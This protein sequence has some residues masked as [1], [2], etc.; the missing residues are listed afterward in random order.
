MRGAAR[1]QHLYSSVLQTRVRTAST[2]PFERRTDSSMVDATGSWKQ[3]QLRVFVHP[4]ADA[5]AGG[6]PVTAFVVPADEVFP[7]QATRAAAA[8]T[9]E[10]ESAFI[11]RGLAGQP[12][13]MRFHVPSGSAMDMC[14][15]AA[16]GAS[17]LLADFGAGKGSRTATVTFQAA[18]GSEAVTA[19]VSEREDGSWRASLAL[20]ATSHVEFKLDAGGSEALLAVLAQLGLSEGQLALGLPLL[21]SGVMGRAKTLVPLTLTEAVHSAQAP[22][23][24]DVFRELCDRM[25]ST[26]IYLHSPICKDLLDFE[27][28]QFP[29]ASGY[30][31]DPA[32]GV[33]AMALALS[34]RATGLGGAS[35]SFSFHQGR[36]MRRPSWIG[37][38]LYNDARSGIEM[39][40]CEG[41]VMPSNGSD[42]EPLS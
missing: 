26:G 13:R 4:A 17:V 22:A 31:E 10:W 37:V 27:C 39:A 11:Q 32:T 25:D 36:A 38:E 34:L 40:A 23:D 33:A 19:K 8:A 15:H 9:C 28:R 24:P 12:G 3:S 2:S 35:P 18:D 1:L 30:P 29:R 42:P 16:L 41:L 21:N 20:A 5:Q 14:A 6:N 7:D